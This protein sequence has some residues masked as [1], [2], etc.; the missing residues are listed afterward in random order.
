M[1]RRKFASIL[2][3]AQADDVTTPANMCIVQPSRLEALWMAGLVPETSSPAVRFV[4]AVPFY[5]LVSRTEFHARV[6]NSDDVRYTNANWI[7]GQT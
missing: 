1:W 7:L 3:R 5:H 2:I 4:A 6:L